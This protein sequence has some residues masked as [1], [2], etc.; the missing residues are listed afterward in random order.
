MVRCAIGYHLHNLKN[1]KNTHGGM[2]LLVKLQ[3]CAKRLIY[4]ATPLAACIRSAV[5][6]NH[7]HYLCLGII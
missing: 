1:V 6:L 3:A 7:M 4:I 2:L 5:N